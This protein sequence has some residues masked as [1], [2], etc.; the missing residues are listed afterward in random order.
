M[1]QDMLGMYSDFTPKFVKTY[2]N[3]GEKMNSAFKKYIDEVKDGV[4]PDEEHSFK[5]S[6]EIIEK[7]YL[8]RVKRWLY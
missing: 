2:E 5:I 8:K 1:Y 3:L 4:F 6:D 7:L